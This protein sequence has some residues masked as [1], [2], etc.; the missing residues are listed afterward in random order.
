M[1]KISK[2]FSTITL[3]LIPVA[4][5]INIAVSLLINALKVPLYLDSIG[6]VL[7]GA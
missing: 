2:D 4:M 1:Q 7:V 6:T 3:A 5:A